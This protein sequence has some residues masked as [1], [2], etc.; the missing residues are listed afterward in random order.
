MAGVLQPVI[1]CNNFMNRILKG[2]D[3]IGRLLVVEFN[4]RE[5][6]VFE[7]VMEVLKNH[8]ICEEA[9]IKE[10]TVLSLPRLDIHLDR[11][12]IYRD[13]K[14]VNL[15][16]KEYDILHLLAV[17]RGRVLSYE[18]IY[19]NVWGEAAF[20]NETNAIGCHVHNLRRKLCDTLTDSPFSIRCI[21]GIGYCFEIKS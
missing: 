20:G 19:K 15:T 10:E 16:V 7:E 12:K 5:F 17:H 2:G 14:E 21:K 1:F 9:K 8:S 18:Q 11:R 3:N 6:H 4:D 13:R